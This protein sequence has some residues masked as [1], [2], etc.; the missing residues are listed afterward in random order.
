MVNKIVS[1]DGH[2]DLF[3]LPMDTFTSR[4]PAHLRDRV[5]RVVDID[6]KPTWVGDG[7]KMGAHAAWMGRGQMTTHRGRRM[8]EAGWQPSHPPDPKLR[9]A[10]LDLDGIEAEV[11]YGIRFVEDSIKDP[12]VVAATYRAYNDF[13][14]EFCA[15]N[16][17]RFIG[18]A[19]IPA[20]SAES[21]SQELCRIGKRGLGL[22]GAKIEWFNGPEP[23]W[24]SMWE[25]M[26]IAAEENEVALSFHI[27]VG[28]GTTTCGPISVE[29]KLK[30]DLPRVSQ[31]THQAVVAMQADECLVAILLCGALE[32]HPGLKVVMAESHIG[33]I[34]YVLDR[35]DMKHKEGM[36]NDLISAKPS[37]LFKRQVWATFQDDKVGARLAQD[38]GP[39]SFCWASDYPHADGIFPDSQDFI[40]DTMGHLDSDLQRKLTFLNAIRL[41]NLDWL[42]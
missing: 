33:W 11:I 24:H 26:W 4:V 9:L 10:D 8:A 15:Y 12:E 39:D 37:E 38:Y 14:A 30:G 7:A 2:M 20:S 5:P 16:P 35:L 41:Y 18:I 3:Y 34:P 31:A 6:S 32:R 27:G 23:I 17:K 40:R 28:H 42:L 13:I 22:R 29:Q 36:Y 19:N 25:P 21:A 1:A